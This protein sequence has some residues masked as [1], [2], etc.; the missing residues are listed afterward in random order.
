[1][2]RLCPLYSSSKGNSTYLSGGGTA[3]LVDVGVSLRALRSGLSSCGLSLDEV[4]AVLITHEH[5]DHVKGLHTL[6]KRYELPVCA[7]I[8]TLEYLE[9]QDLVPP[10]A[11]LVPFEGPLRIG[12]LEITAFSTPHDAVDSVGFKFAF[13]DGT[14]AAITTDL[15]HVSDEVRDCL[16]GC[17]LVMLE[18]N[19]DRGMLDCSAYPYYLKR[20]IKSATGHLANE[21][22]AREIVRLLEKGT[23]RFV[24]S[25]LSEQNNLPGIAYETARA[26]LDRERAEEN[27]DYILKVAPAREPREVIV[28]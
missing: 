10:G 7:S 15:G 2:A 19:Y 27:L 20:R 6:L 4:R 28:F 11:V 13:P 25:H 24:L 26:A 23:G 22:C 5:S 12:A 17:D 18:S 14:T 21:D 3:V 8:R 9:A 16:T 1:M